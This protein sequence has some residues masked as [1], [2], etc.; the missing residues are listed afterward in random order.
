MLKYVIILSF[1]I[2]VLLSY[3]C[4]AQEEY[5][6][7]NTILKN[8]IRYNLQNKP[9]NGIVKVYY[10]N[11][12]LLLEMPYKNGLMDGIARGYR[13]DGKLYEEIIYRKSR[14]IKKIFYPTYKIIV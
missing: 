7:Q 6:M 9:L 14:E 3:P 8:G 5:T 12:V 1:Q 4:I 10:P 11:G 13:E 2:T